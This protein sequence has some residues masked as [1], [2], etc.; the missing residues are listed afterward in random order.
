[1]GLQFMTF[2][3]P[4]AIDSRSS[5]LAQLHQCLVPELWELL[6]IAAQAAELQG[7]QLFLVGGAVRDLLLIELSPS[8]SQSASPINPLLLQ[9]IDLVV[10]GGAQLIEAGAGVELARSLQ[11]T[12]PQARLEIH[13]KFQTAALIW[14]DDPTFQALSLDIATA[15]T[16]VYP[17]PAA[18]PEVSAS[19]IQQDLRRRDFTINAM[20]I[21]LTQPQGELLDRFQGVKDLQAGLIRVLHAHSFIDDPTRIYRAVRFAVRL[22][23]QIE[24]ETVGYFRA[25]I[26]SGIYQQIRDPEHPHFQAVAPALQTRLKA[27]LKYIFQTATWQTAL[28][29]LAEL[30]A[31]QCIHPALTAQHLA[32]NSAIWRALGWAARG[33]PLIARPALPAWILLIEVLLANLADDDRQE[34][35]SGLRLPLESCDRLAQFATAQAE[36]IANLSACQQPSQIV[37][38]L[39]PYALPILLLVGVYGDRPLRR[40]LCTY[41]T[42]WSHVKAPLNGK[43]LKALG[44]KPGE[45]FR[46]ILAALKDATLNGEIRDRASAKA[47][48]RNHYPV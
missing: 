35:A 46:A 33:S 29:Q 36:I 48:L 45:S 23:F 16:E 26:A 25:A 1:V 38:V 32:T 18:N 42:Q 43:D 4:S 19:S 10:D 6:A 3:P 40:I 15:R 20:A 37:R 21:R 7:W 34:A 8:Q 9:D 5:T 24:A 31:L 27:E 30:E 22:G 12:Y 14:Q 17:Y 13:G 44:Y 39:E 41:V 47:Y 2:Y 28:K 11:E